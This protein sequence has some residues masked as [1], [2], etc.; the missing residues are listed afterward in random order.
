MTDIL[1]DWAKMPE[2]E[3]GPGVRKRRIDGRGASLVMIRIAGGTSAPRHAHAHEQF[4]QVVSGTGS[5]E[6]EQGR[7][8]FGP[9]CVFHF[10]AETW[11]AASF[12]SD[13]VL[14]EVNLVSPGA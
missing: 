9:G 14:V 6:T 1:V 10:P 8:S 11:H 12:A 13:T 5:L 3:A 2:T 7:Q 4:V